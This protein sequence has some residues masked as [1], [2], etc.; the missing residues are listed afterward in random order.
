MRENDSTLDTAER[1][2]S[3]AA[4]ERIEHVAKVTAEL[5]AVKPLVDALECLLTMGVPRHRVR[6]ES[7]LSEKDITRLLERQ[8]PVSGWVPESS[9]WTFE[10]ISAAKGRLAAWIED[11]ELPPEVS[12]YAETPIFTA[13]YN[14]I[15]QAQERRS[16]TVIVGGFG[17]GKSS[18]AEAAVTK[19]PRRRDAPGLVKIE[20]SE[21]E[22]TNSQLMKAIYFRLINRDPFTIGDEVFS[23]V[24]RLLRPGDV[25]ILDECQRLAN[26]SHGRGIEAIRQLYD[27]TG[28]RQ[29]GASIVLL[30]NPLANVK[31]N[32]LD[33]KLYGA[34]SGRARVF[35]DARF[36]HLSEYD[37]DEFMA[38][39]GVSGI[40]VRKALVR[41]FAGSKEGRPAKNAG[42]FHALTRV[43]DDA[44]AANGGA[45]SADAILEML[46]PEQ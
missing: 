45:L 32:I 6:S 19:R 15:V 11:A 24:V 25:L 7:G 4:K 44:A 9:A 43:F 23:E 26:Y 27:A 12:S 10:A 33:E 41:R 14:Q 8:A 22:R 39:K 30:G 20:V 2:Q 21:Y 42:G 28:S 17:V 18:A 36:L 37:I 29:S 34:F 13:I 5:E 40:A 3:F 31:G 35:N 16:L 38:H 1:Y 46:P